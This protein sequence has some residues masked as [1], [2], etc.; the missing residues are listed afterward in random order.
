VV[1]VFPPPAKKSNLLLQNLE[2][3][4]AAREIFGFLREKRFVE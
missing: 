1:K 2:A 4:E 3:A